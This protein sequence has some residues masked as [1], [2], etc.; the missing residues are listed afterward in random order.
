MCAA[1]LAVR[2]KSVL[3]LERNDRLGAVSALRICLRAIPTIYFLAGTPYLLV[4]LGT[5]SS[6]PI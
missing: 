6:N 5:K 2:G 1:L 3:V 4:A